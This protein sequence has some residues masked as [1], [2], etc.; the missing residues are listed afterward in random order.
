M[1]SEPTTIASAARLIAE[2]LH[3]QYNRDHLPVFRAAGLDPARLE[4]SG[5]RYPWRGMQK[6]WVEAARVTNDPTFGLVVGANIRPTTFHAL[7]F[8]WIASRTLLESL[9]RLARYYK[10]LS[11]APYGVVLH[12][13]GDTWFL[14]NTVEDHGNTQADR[15]ATDAVM[16]AIIRLCKQASDNHFH[17]VGVRMHRPAP[18]NIDA[19]VAALEAPVYFG[20]ERRGLLFDKAELEKPLPGDNLELAVA[21]DEI[22]EN[23]IAG[24]EPERVSTEVR[25]LLIELLP[26]GNAS[27]EAIARQMN[28][29]LSTL[30]RQ[31]ASESTNYKQIR[32]QTRAALAEKYVR[33]GEHSLS[34]IAYLLGFSDQSNFSRAF[35]RWTGQSPGQYGGD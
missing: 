35:R 21:H 14:E 24:L 25:K 4:V 29:S 13:E 22:A 28:R 27:Q 12:D 33:E 17:P 2:T 20:Q 23:Y 32:E 8:S 15:L 26:S 30:Q 3:R 9:Q 10:L 1:L 18:D 5:A 19:Y 6:L 34:Q 31:L 11:N 7:G 16:M